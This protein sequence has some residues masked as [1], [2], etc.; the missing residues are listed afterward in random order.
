MKKNIKKIILFLLDTIR[1][2]RTIYRNYTSPSPLV[3]SPGHYAY[4]R[5]IDE[6]LNESYLYFK[7]YF[8]E[9]IFLP[10]ERLRKYAIE[11]AL[12]NDKGENKYYMEFGVYTGESTNFF[13][14]KLNKNLNAFDSFEGFNEDWVGHAHASGDFSLNKKI[15]KLNKNVSLEI[16]WVQETL[17]NFIK[18][19]PDMK[20]NFVHM[21]MDTYNTS[22]FILENIKPYLEHKAIICFDELYNFE[23]WKVG[24]FK[25]LTE[26]FNE[27]EFTYKCFSNDGAQ[28]VIEY[29]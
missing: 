9:A 11:T 26:T 5:F 1:K 18:L 17:P 14:S 23:G 10:K 2:I 6:E 3:Y 19:N 25:A 28:V 20:I 15:P 16:G 21:D 8:Y 22:K 24:E 13:S 4:K 12:K 27:N 7:K 29:N